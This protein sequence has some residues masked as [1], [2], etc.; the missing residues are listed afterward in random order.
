MAELVRCMRVERELCARCDAEPPGPPPS[1]MSPFALLVIIPSR[2]F[3]GADWLISVYRENGSGLKCTK[4][5]RVHS[6]PWLEFRLPED[7]DELWDYVLPVRGQLVVLR[8]RRATKQVVLYRLATSQ[9]QPLSEQV[10]A[11]G[12]SRAFCRCFASEDRWVCILYK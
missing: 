3:N 7:E 1:S 8:L 12:V 10:I 6:Q 2:R 9:E 4:D 5:P 11:E